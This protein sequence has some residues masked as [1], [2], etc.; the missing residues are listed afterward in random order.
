MLDYIRKYTIGK[1]GFSNIVWKREI[2]HSNRYQIVFLLDPTGIM[3]ELLFIEKKRTKEVG[4]G[5]FCRQKNWQNS[6]LLLV[7]FM[8]VWYVDKKWSRIRGNARHKVCMVLPI[9]LLF[10]QNPP[11]FRAESAGPYKEVHVQVSYAKTIS[12]FVSDSVRGHVFRTPRIY[13]YMY[14][15]V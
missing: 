6:V 1:F 5:G 13:M 3:A 9:S 15:D 11:P 8:N 7:S 14:S 2:F 4:S 12:R 10:E